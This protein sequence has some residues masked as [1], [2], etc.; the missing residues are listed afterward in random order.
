MK[1]ERDST[2]SVSVWPVGFGFPVTRKAKTLGEAREMANE[3]LA[4]YPNAASAMI[5]E[6]PAFVPYRSKV[7]KRAA[8]KKKRRKK[9]A[10]LAGQETLN[11]VDD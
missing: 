10:P 8:P 4:K 3:M 5:R 2:W 11:R 9:G 7:V 6:K 1:L